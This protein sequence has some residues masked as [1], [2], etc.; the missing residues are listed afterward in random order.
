MSTAKCL[1]GSS[2][3]KSRNSLI[4]WTIVVSSKMAPLITIAKFTDMRT[5][6][7]GYLDAVLISSAI[8]I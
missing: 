3:S 5:M 8:E 6:I 4:N 7:N 2:E 1:R